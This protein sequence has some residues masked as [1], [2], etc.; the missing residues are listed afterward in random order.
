LLG[1]EG[2]REFLFHCRHDGP[3]PLVDL[4]SEVSSGDD[5]PRRSLP[6]LAVDDL[7]QLATP[8]RSSA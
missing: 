5:R 6:A 3:T 7:A 4:A 8:L 1:A 2:N